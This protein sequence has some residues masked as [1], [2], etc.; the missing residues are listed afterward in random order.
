M[1]MGAKIKGE[2]ISNSSNQNLADSSLSSSLGVLCN[3]EAAVA[4]LGEI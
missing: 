2:H 3:I 4:S 1:A